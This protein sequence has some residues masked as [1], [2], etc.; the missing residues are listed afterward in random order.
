MLLSEKIH[1]LFFKINKSLLISLSFL[2]LILTGACLLTLP[3]SHTNGQW[4]PFIDALFTATSASCVTGLAVWDTGNDLSVFGQLVLLFLIQVGG[5]GIMTVTTLC[6]IGLGKRIHI[7]ER[8]LISESLNQN[9]PSGILKMTISIIKYTFIIEGFFGTLLSFYFYD[10]LGARA[11]YLGYWHAIS[12]FCNA[13]FDLLGNYTSLVNYQEDYFVNICIMCL[14]ILGGI[15]FTVIDDLHHQ[16]S[17]RKFALHTKIVLIVNTGLILIGTLGLWALEHN[18]PLTLGSLSTDGQWL[19]S[20]FQSVSAR[21]AGFNTINLGD[22][23]GAALF[24]LITLMYIGASPTSTGGGIKTT[25]FAVLICSTL[26]QLRNKQEVVLF[27]RRLEDSTVAKANSI[28]ILTTLWL[29]IS[30]FLLLTLDTGNSSFE[31]ILF[32]LFSAFG[33][34]GL[35]IGITGEW[36]IWCKLILIATMYIGRVGILTFGLSFFNRKLDRVRYPSE[37]IIIG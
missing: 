28:F 11:F 19:A 17:W 27:R 5:L 33:T 1:R 37:N 18:N 26:A 12:A 35:G 6:T 15:G 32:E 30:F 24:F 21:T 22:L 34:V 3:I 23:S 8:L 25:T 4:H 36:N 20:A 9:G 10:Q 2:L 31:F 16:R 14:I 7:G 29:V 13:G